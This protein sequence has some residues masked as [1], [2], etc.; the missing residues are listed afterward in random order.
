MT[1]NKKDQEIIASQ[2]LLPLKS[3][4]LIIAPLVAI[5]VTKKSNLNLKTQT[6]NLRN[7]SSLYLHQKLIS[8]EV[9]VE[10]AV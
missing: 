9:Q 1:L 3:M 2:V 7:N 6:K 4:L 8:K 10:I 5:K